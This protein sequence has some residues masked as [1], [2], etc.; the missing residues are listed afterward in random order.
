M[1]RFFDRHKLLKLTHGEADN[2]KRPISTNKIKSVP[3]NV[4][5][6]KA[7]GPY[8]FIGEFYQ[9]FKNE[10]ISILYNLFQKTESKGTLI[11]WLMLYVT[12]ARLKCPG[13]WSNTSLD[14]AM[15]VFFFRY[16]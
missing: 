1:D 16:D 15:K 7:S 12:L 13:V 6:I 5:K 8:G 14:V 2:L 4:T 9:A 10:I 11:W 3:N